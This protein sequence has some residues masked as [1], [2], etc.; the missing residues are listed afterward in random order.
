[1]VLLRHNRGWVFLVV[2]SCYLGVS[3]GMPPGTSGSPSRNHR[4]CLD[5]M[6]VS[7]MQTMIGLYYYQIEFLKGGGSSFSKF[8]P[9][10]N[11]PWVDLAS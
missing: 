8:G 6:L 11:A 2:N 3:S 9:T 10:F 7:K 1:M 4:L 5:K